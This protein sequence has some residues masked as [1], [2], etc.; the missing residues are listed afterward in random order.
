[1]NLIE[2]YKRFPANADCIKYL[3]KIKWKGA[4]VCPY[5]GS[6]KYSPYKSGIR[7][8]CN[9]CNMSFSVTVKTVFH[10]T[11]LDLQKWF[12]A[13]HFILNGEY[14]LSARELGKQLDVTKDTALLLL[15]KIRKAYAE[16]N[17]LLIKISNN[18]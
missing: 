18:E 7:Y 13:I 16:D 10:R 2:I 5:C 4:P 6:S 14:L 8:K 11:R 1:M 3:E 17:Q 9:K 12:L 15:N